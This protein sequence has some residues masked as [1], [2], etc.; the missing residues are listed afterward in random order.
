MFFPS[1]GSRTQQAEFFNSNEG[2]RNR[3]PRPVTVQLAL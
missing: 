3:R 1:R 2:F